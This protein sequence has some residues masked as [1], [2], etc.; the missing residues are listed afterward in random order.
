MTCCP[1]GKQ[2]SGYWHWP[3]QDVTGCGEH[4]LH[5]SEAREGGVVLDESTHSSLSSMGKRAQEKASCWGLQSWMLTLSTAEAE[6]SRHD[7]TQQAT[8]MM[9]RGHVQIAVVWVWLMCQ[10]V[11]QN[12]IFRRSFNFG[13]SD[14]SG[15][16]RKSLLSA[17]IAWV[18]IPLVKRKFVRGVLKDLSSILSG[19][20]TTAIG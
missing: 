6:T 10:R 18:I 14:V 8:N 4:P 1:W 7:E 3:G 16:D 20:P 15:D 9:Q 17:L 11:T 12:L 5:S 19:L 2:D 13:V